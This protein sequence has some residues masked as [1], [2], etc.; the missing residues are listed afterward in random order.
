VGNGYDELSM[1]SGNSLP[2]SSG[3]CTTTFDPVADVLL[4]VAEA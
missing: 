2:G 3:C 1:S 4:V